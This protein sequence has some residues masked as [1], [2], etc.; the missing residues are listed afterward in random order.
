MYLGLGPVVG[1]THIF[2]GWDILD[3]LKP[4]RRHCF[5]FQG[6][7]QKMN[8]YTFNITSWALQQIPLVYMYKLHVLSFHFSFHQY[9]FISQFVLRVQNSSTRRIITVSAR[10]LCGNIVKIGAG[11]WPQFPNLMCRKQ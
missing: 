5:W 7:L 10:I 11:G 4:C 3:R 6:N 8:R 9:F 1:Q 2:A